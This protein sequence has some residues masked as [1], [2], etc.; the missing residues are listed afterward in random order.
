MKSK[1]IIWILLFL[2]IPTICS[3]LG[4][5]LYEIVVNHSLNIQNAL[6]NTLKIPVVLFVM[7]SCI[8]VLMIIYIIIHVFKKN[9]ISEEDTTLITLEK[10]EVDKIK[11]TNSELQA[12]VKLLQGEIDLLNKKIDDYKSIEDLVLTILE[13]KSDSTIKEITDII[14]FQGVN[15]SKEDITYAISKLQN[16]KPPKIISGWT[17][18]KL[19]KC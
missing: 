15:V 18:G 1:D 14:I 16:S 17:T 19:R 7:L 3:T 6:T 11:D 13:E 2:I 4:T 9:E 12:E 8:S 10:D 5:A